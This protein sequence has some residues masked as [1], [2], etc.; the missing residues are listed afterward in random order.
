[1]LSSHHGGRPANIPLLRQGDSEKALIVSAP[2]PRL[3]QKTLEDARPAAEES[4]GGPSAVFLYNHG[5]GL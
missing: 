1:V 5:S 3:R 4:T 2:T